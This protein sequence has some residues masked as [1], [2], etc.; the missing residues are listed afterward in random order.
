MGNG[1]KKEINKDYY[2]G[3]KALQRRMRL[4]NFTCKLLFR[5]FMFSFKNIGTEY[6]LQFLE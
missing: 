5:Y 3:N 6:L 1:N 2:E 4:F